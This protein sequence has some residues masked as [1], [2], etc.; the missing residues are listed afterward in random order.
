MTKISARVIED[1]AYPGMDA[2]LTTLVL[3]YPRFIH[4][5]LM[6][7]RVFSRNAASSR[8]IPV[9]KMLK[10]AEE[11][12]AN[13]IFW[14]KN[15][16]GMQSWEELD[17]DEKRLV[18]EEWKSLQDKTILSVAKL[19]RLGF[20]KQY[21]N[22]PLE[23]FG[24]IETI[25]T[26]TNFDNF[27]AQRAHGDA[28]PEFGLSQEMNTGLAV[29]VL[30]A[31][32]ASHPRVLN[33]GEWHL[34]FLKKEERPEFRGISWGHEK[35]LTYIK[36]SAARCSR[37]SYMNHEGKVTTVEEDLA[38]YEKLAGAVPMHS[39][40]MEHQATPYTGE[41]RG[42]FKGFRQWRSYMPNNVVQEDKR[43]LK[44]GAGLVDE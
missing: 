36:R 2:R 9:S 21:A 27:V 7:H 19:N 16:P 28:H 35:Y 4:A 40:P 6:T 33:F 1:S 14:G 25:L 11:D 39:S 34:P 30:N 15:Q 23:W 17:P 22:R 26:G 8:A 44:W 24:W 29:E 31:L 32:N 20:H 42:N 3:T 12:P 38:H 37:V 10:R 5:E 13:P 41:T 18:Q 43:L